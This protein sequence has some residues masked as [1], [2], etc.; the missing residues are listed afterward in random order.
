MIT[1]ATRSSSD[2]K[3]QK[4]IHVAKVRNGFVPHTQREVVAK[5]RG[6]KIAT[7]PFINLPDK[8]PR[9]IR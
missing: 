4:L 7:C 1:R 5:L 9:R 3:R 2:I 6:L 8:K